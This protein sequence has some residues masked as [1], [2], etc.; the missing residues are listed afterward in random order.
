MKQKILFVSS[1]DEILGRFEILLRAQSERWEGEFVRSGDHALEVLADGDCAVV[2][3][4]PEVASMTG[5]E[6]LAAVSD[7]FPETVRVIITDPDDFDP[8][9][10]MVG[11][12]HQFLSETCEEEGLAHTLHRAARVREMLEDRGLKTLMTKIETLPSLPSL[13]LQIIRELQ[14]A[15]PSITR[16]AR[17]ISDDV[18]MAAKTLQLVNSVVFAPRVRITDPMRAAIYLGIDM[19]KALVL[20]ANVFKQFER[21]QVAELTIGE[22]WDHS[23]Y[24]ATLSQKILRE[25]GADAAV[26]DQA[27]MAGVLHDIGKLVLA[28][29]LPDNYIKAVE[30]SRNNDIPLVEAERVFFGASHA[31]IGAFLMALWGVPDA[32]VEAIQ[33][34]HQ[35]SAAPQ[36]EQGAL[37]AVHVANGLA[38]QRS[39]THDHVLETD[40]LDLDYLDGIGMAERLA[41]WRRLC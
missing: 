4:G 20:S 33:F 23:M 16:I 11:A 9:L 13:Y 25:E 26:A 5:A 41:S 29:N 28:A 14:T 2:V 15:N 39:S 17:T 6:L 12:A 27:F 34:H 18:S 36:A 40:H 30:M 1:R 8:T 19:L 3:T 10:G 38:V 35:P 21:I 7:R 31:E 22:L 24:V 37:M 32:V